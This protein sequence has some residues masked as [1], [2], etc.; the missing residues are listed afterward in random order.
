MFNYQNNNK[1]MKV[2]FKNSELSLKTKDSNLLK[3]IYSLGHHQIRLSSDYLTSEIISSKQFK[4]GYDVDVLAESKF[5]LSSGGTSGTLSSAQIGIQY[6][7]YSVPSSE[8]H[9]LYVCVAG[10]Q[11][12][13]A[14][15]GSSSKLNI[16]LSPSEGK[17]NVNG[18]NHDITVGTSGITY[19][20]F[21]NK[22]FSEDWTSTARVNRIWV[23][24]M[25][26]VLLLDCVP[27]MGDNNMPCLFD[28]VSLQKLYSMI[29][30]SGN[31]T[32]DPEQ[33]V[34]FGYVEYE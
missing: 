30:S 19:L 23:E 11:N 21:L 28:K 24:D 27:Y 12:E 10:I 31:T 26:G 20:Q 7:P 2:I 5:T 17:V 18:T 34:K 29:D 22:T 14:F 9:R 3:S 25:N 13:I 32:T 6:K 33:A 16:L 8:N 15:T 4:L 1:I